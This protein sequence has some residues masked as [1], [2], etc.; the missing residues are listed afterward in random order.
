MAYK[1]KSVKKTENVFNVRNFLG[2]MSKILLCK[3]NRLISYALI[4][5]GYE[6]KSIFYKNYVKRTDV[7]YQFWGTNPWNKACVRIELVLYC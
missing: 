1:N 6:P 3:F 5:W 2:K 4:L 7:N